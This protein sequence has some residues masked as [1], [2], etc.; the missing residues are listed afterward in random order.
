MD[1]PSSRMDT[2]SSR[3]LLLPEH[4]LVQILSY[5]PILELLS[6]VNR[7]CKQLKDV[8]EYNSVLWDDISLDFPFVGDAGTIKRILKHSVGFSTLLL[9]YADIS[10]RSDE[11]DFL[12]TTNLCNAKHL[13]WLDISGSQVSTLCFLKHLPNLKILNVSECLN[14]VDSDCK[15]IADVKTLDQLYLS[16]TNVTA[17]TVV[18]IGSSLELLVLDISG[19]VITVEQCDEVINTHMHYIQVSIDPSETVESIDRLKAKWIDCQ[20]QHNVVQR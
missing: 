8:I 19:I 10:C 5:I 1:T 3:L 20:L 13:F 18:D 2:P 4:I 6:S 12:Y 7:T 14:I 17:S 9:P 11:L 15:V 16:F